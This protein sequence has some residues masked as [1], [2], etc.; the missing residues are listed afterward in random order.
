MN[1]NVYMENLRK[2]LFEKVTLMENCDY[3]TD[4]ENDFLSFFELCIYEMLESDD[5]FFASVFI[6]LRRKIS[7]KLNTA[8]AA[9]P[10]GQNFILYI[11]PEYFLGCSILE[12]QAL[13]KHEVYHIISGHHLRAKALKKLYSS[14]AVDLAM[15]ITINQYI[16]NLP[17]WS[18]TLEKVS[19]SYNVYLK[20]EQ[21]LE[22]YAKVLH[23]AINKLIKNK[24]TNET[25][26]INNF[27]DISSEHSLWDEAL[28]NIDNNQIQ[29][30]IKKIVDN[31]SKLK[32]PK[33]VE[34]LLTKLYYKPEVS[35]A[36]YLK[37]IIGN[38]PY[39][40][41]KTIT[42]KDRRQP[43]RLE[44]RGK[45][46]DHTADIIVAIDISGSVT[47]EEIKII[48][49]EIFGLVK[50]YHS[51]ITII[52][53]D[54]EIRRVYIVKNPREI[55]KK[56]DT[57]GG[58]KF[59]PVFKYLNDHN[60]NNSILIYFTD[61]LGEEELVTKVKQKQ[62]LWVLTGKKDNLSLKNPSGKVIRLSKAEEKE[63]VNMYEFV[64]NEMRDIS[65]EW[66]K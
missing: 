32:L 24:S 49:S 64:R 27:V 44:L 59:N 20:E 50:M 54:N 62:V 9:V 5:N 34:E 12:M 53:C 4:F 8:L 55:R 47:D 45:L 29:E 19:L 15:D 38:V 48:M 16:M 7:F 39:G 42:R 3:S 35:W 60:L 66:A 52:E 40:T 11:N 10:Y 36:Q 41:K 31:T 33:S 37:K 26:D 22:E 25:V 23:G 14:L 28:E 61:G 51:K 2:K 58:T 43:D 65:T 46:T 1:K 56:I 13:I 30:I 18:E 57:K 63:K 6:Q 21:I 17:A